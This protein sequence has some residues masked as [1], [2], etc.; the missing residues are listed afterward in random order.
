MLI[1]LTATIH[2]K[3][4]KDYKASVDSRAR[5][6]EYVSNIFFLL[7]DSPF[8]KIVLCDNSNY[9]HEIFS[10]LVDFAKI[11]GKEFEYM[12]FD[13]DVRLVHERGRGA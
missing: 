9:S 7:T 4:Q 8:D 5:L 2:P 13:G 3:T 10:L 12:T 1:C 6:K 11:L